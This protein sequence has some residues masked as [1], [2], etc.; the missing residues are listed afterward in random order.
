M[1]SQERRMESQERNL[2]C[3][4]LSLLKLSYHPEWG[5]SSEGEEHHADFT[6]V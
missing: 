4:K 2:D 6:P 1:G 5:K 3:N